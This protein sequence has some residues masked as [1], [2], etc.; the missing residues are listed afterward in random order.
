M[1]MKKAGTLLQLQWSLERGRELFFR[2]MGLT[3]RQPFSQTAILVPQR[4]LEPQSST[5]TTAHNRT[6]ACV[7]QLA[8]QVLP[9][10]ASRAFKQEFFQP[11]F[12]RRNA[13]LLLSLACSATIPPC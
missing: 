13:G 4:F 11:A 7:P 2:D 1:L 12:N 5:L 8:L 3:Y 6:M 10:R 9:A